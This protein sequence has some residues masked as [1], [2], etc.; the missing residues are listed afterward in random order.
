MLLPAKFTQNMLQN[1]IEIK[2]FYTTRRQRW[3]LLEIP[4]N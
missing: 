4:N 1:N 2:W 3:R